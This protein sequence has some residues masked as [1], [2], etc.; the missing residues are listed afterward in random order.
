ML[1]FIS[2]IFVLE[3]LHC[4]YTAQKMKFSIKDFFI[5]YAVLFNILLRSYLTI[6]MPIPNNLL[7][8]L[9]SLVKEFGV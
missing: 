2:L 9:F 6:A 3:S 5:F 7:L 4:L 1:N 8:Y